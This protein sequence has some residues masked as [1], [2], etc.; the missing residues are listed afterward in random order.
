MHKI[1]II[2]A[3]NRILFRRNPYHIATHQVK[4]PTVGAVGR[5][6]NPEKV[7]SNISANIWYPM[8]LLKLAQVS[9]WLLRLLNSLGITEFPWDY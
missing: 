3:S 6:E 7:F 5:F 9:I 4:N 2:E 1:Q 8:V